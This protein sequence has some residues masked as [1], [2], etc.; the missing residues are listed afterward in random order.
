MNKFAGLA[1]MV[2]VLGAAL[3]FESQALTLGR[4]KVLTPLGQPLLAEIDVPDLSQ[5]EANTLRIGVATPDA[6]R[7][8]GLEFNPLVSNLGITGKRRTD[9]RAY[10]EIKSV[11]PINEPFLDLVLELSWAT[12]RMMRDYTL[13]LDPP[14]AG[15]MPLVTPTTTLPVQTNAPP[16]AA[17]QL[18]APQAVPAPAP[19]TIVVKTA[20]A[21]AAI[22]IPTS[23]PLAK[24]AT[25]LKSK[26]KI[27][28]VRG[29]T[30]AALARAN[31][32]DGISLDQMLVAM[33]RSNPDAFVDGNVNRLK[34]GA[35]LE[36]PEGA[37]ASN[38]KITDAK[39]SLK[40]Q[41]VDFQEYRK[42]LAQNAV[43]TESAPKR[44]AA[45]KV[46]ASVV[47]K[48]PNVSTPDKLTL[49]KPKA[50]PAVTKAPS[51]PSAE[52]KLA[53]DLAKQ[54]N[55]ARTAELEK[56]IADLKNVAVTTAVPPAPQI[57]PAAPV[58]VVSAPVQTP[59]AQPKPPTTQS[60]ADSFA[61]SPYLLPVT[62][63]IAALLGGAFLWFRNKRRKQNSAKSPLTEF[64]VEG[65]HTRQLSD[66]IF[67][68]IGGARVNTQ[69][70]AANAATMVLTP[71]QLAEPSVSPSDVDPVAEA[72]VYLAYDRDVQAE[73][74]L[75]EAMRTM[76]ERLDIDEKLLEIYAKRGDLRAF[77]S[78]ATALHSKSETRSPNWTQVCDW[79][80]N[81]G[82]TLPIFAVPGAAFSVADF[83]ATQQ[84]A[85]TNNSLTFR[86]ATPLVSE[87]P[88]DPT[89]APPPQTD[90]FINFDMSALSLDFPPRTPV[91]QPVAQPVITQAQIAIDTNEL[92]DPK[93]ALAEE[94][95]SIGDKA[96]ARALIEEVIAMGDTANAQKALA[97][98]ANL[99]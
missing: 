26:K 99:G 1:R 52:E 75:K 53:A 76:P 54:A 30:A 48:K 79:A 74:I 63:G 37:D 91:S 60:A 41:A 6:F 81:I 68:Q 12:G 69:E 62:G 71:T 43:V 10:L 50:D 47:D 65:M 56:N 44:E 51:L 24:P 19:S 87:L 45:G 17:A 4:L 55:A 46:T 29:D 40:T 72:D 18:P 27:K 92:E 61:N 32:S 86:A 57:A 36:I 95:L 66:T 25:A 39:A 5:E 78:V 89:P 13:L 15:Q 77:E 42:K 16:I 73:E 23:T 82:S 7:T 70:E 22:A 84:S 58:A 88:P 67:G 2:V 64:N 80:K 94:Y 38:I 49:E 93:L 85:Y 11:Q 34:A 59:V 8:A 28:V 20:E 90:G 14:V 83:P 31:L 3:T 33:L 96:G 98:L 97:M 21:P 35:V 9:G